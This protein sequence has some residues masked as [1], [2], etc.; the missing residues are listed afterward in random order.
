M[1]IMDACLQGTYINTHTHTHQRAVKKIIAV[2][3]VGGKKLHRRS[4]DSTKSERRN[5]TEPKETKPE[6]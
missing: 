2:K 3:R 6:S 1:A 5:S 4:I